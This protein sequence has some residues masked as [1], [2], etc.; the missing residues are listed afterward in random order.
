MPRS[1]ASQ[2]PDFI[3]RGNSNPRFSQSSRDPRRATARTPQAPRRYGRNPRFAQTT[4]IESR[5]QIACPEFLRP[6]T[7]AFDK[8]NNL[9]QEVVKNSPPDFMTTQVTDLYKGMKHFCDVFVQHASVHFSGVAPERDSRGAMQFTS[10]YRSAKTFVEQWA[11]FIDVINEMETEG[12][13]P[14]VSRINTSFDEIF[15]AIL[16]VRTAMPRMRFR[17]DIAVLA[18]SKLQ[19]G[20]IALRDEISAM[21]LAPK[22]SRFVGFSHSLFKRR[23]TLLMHSIGDLYDRA[24][25]HSCLPVGTT[26]ATRAVISSAIAAISTAVNMARQCEQVFVVLK[27]EVLNVNTE[28]SRVCQE[29]NFPLAVSVVFDDEIREEESHAVKQPEA[30]VHV[31]NL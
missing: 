14:Y 31:V 28:L 10:M 15:N 24:L 6:F 22:E 25:P 2:F 1:K 7:L 11:A 4:P 3:N 17:T 16:Q 26:L 21:I 20:V 23:I 8:L 5:R 12:L 27:D 29:I 18:L 30:Q 9:F 19:N 13:G